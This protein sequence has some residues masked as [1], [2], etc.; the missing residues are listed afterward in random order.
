L[1][2][3]WQRPRIPPG[4]SPANCCR[5]VT[6]TCWSKLRQHRWTNG[7]GAEYVLE[8]QSGFWR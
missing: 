4:C 6:P 3:N 8:L 7:V 5:Q 1:M 2:R